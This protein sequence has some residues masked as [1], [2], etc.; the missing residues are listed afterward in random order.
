MNT[1]LGIIAASVVF[2]IPPSPKSVMMTG[3]WP[4]GFDSDFKSIAIVRGLLDP[5]TFHCIAH[6]LACGLN[7]VFALHTATGPRDYKMIA[8]VLQRIGGFPDVTH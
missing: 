2:P 5:Q 3:L 7:I 4:S 1:G 6:V 8:G